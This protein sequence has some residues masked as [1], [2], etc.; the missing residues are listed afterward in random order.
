[1]RCPYLKVVSLEWFKIVHW[2]YQCIYSVI[3]MKIS[4]LDE[5]MP[6][7]MIELIFWIM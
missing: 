4:N 7:S 3:L 1:M 6:L 5:E 2:K